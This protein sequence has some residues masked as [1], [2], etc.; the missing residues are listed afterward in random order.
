MSEFNSAFTNGIA[1]VGVQEVFF[2]F[3]ILNLSL[4]Q[5]NAIIEQIKKNSVF[6][7]PDEYNLIRLFLSVVQEALSIGE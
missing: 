4:T 2:I 5:E 1:R 3:L 6:N 7:M